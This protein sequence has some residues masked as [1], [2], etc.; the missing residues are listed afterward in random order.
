[1]NNLP[2]TPRQQQIMQG[3]I[4]HYADDTRILAVLVFGSLGR[5][6]WDDYSDIDLDIVMA[7]GLPI[8]AQQELADLCAFLKRQHGLDALIIADSE[9]GDV[10]LSNLLEFSIRYHVLYDT[11][12][13]ILDSMQRLHG[14]VSLDEIRASANWRYRSDP[15]EPEAIL[16]QC[17]RYT[18]ELHNAIKRQRYWMAVEMLHRIRG[19]L[20]T[21]YAVSHGADRAMQHFE[22]HA[23]PDVQH[24]LMQIVP[25][26]NLDA[27][28]DAPRLVLALL[29]DHL[30]AF[31]KGQARLTDA[32]RAIL[33][34]ISQLG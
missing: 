27:L 17:I 24:R 16:N 20:M 4:D 10:V 19:L 14:T 30:D 26:A 32:Q 29:N 13:A 8:N 22:A 6:N 31:S 3:I 12:P 5:G 34:Q 21:L 9:E 11:K 7:D 25:A 28:R 15:E 1:M 33:H 2:G 18:L 23:S